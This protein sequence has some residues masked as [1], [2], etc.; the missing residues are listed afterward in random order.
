MQDVRL[1][2]SRKS[3][4]LVSSRCRRT[5]VLE[6]GNRLIIKYSV[7]NSSMMGCKLLY[8]PVILIDFIALVKMVRIFPTSSNFEK[9]IRKKRTA[10][11]K[12]TL[13]VFDR[14]HVSESE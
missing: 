4:L 13:E 6:S 9:L 10:S 2:T 5:S 3:W 8:S 11:T 1:A 7:V 14:C 12:S